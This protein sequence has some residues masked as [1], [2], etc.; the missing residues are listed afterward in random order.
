MAAYWYSV[1]SIIYGRVAHGPDYKVCASSCPLRFQA[2]DLVI[3]LS[4]PSNGRAVSSLPCCSRCGT[5]QTA[6]CV[7]D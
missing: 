5:R 1:F 6:P 2:C 7:L 3:I 4:Y